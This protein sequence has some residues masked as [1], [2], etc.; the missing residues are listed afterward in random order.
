[1]SLFYIVDGYN[2]I[3]RSTFFDKKTLRESRDSFFSFIES[4]RPQGSLKNR[5]VVVFDGSSEV[6]GFKEDHCFE[7]IFTR[8]QSADEMIKAMVS[9]S[10]HPK[11]II[12]V[13]DDKELALSVRRQGAKIMS[14]TEFLKKKIQHS[15]SLRTPACRKDADARFELNIV[16]RERITEEVRRI[17]LAKK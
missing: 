2:V 10:G 4:T 16:E 14:T 5:L 1:M 8:G 12:V 17:W 11:N 7:V 6:F 3:K 15:L 9:D 13:T